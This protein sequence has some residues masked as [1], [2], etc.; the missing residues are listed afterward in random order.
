[1]TKTKKNSKHLYPQTNFYEYV[2]NDWIHSHQ[3]QTKKTPYITNFKIVSDKIDKELQHL[4]MNK[5]I[6]N[7]KNINNLFH[8]YIHN[9]EFIITNYIY[10]L[11]NEVRD[12]FKLDFH[13]G[14]YKLMAW[15]HEK[16]IH[17][18]L[19]ININNDEKDCSKYSLYIQESG[20]I[21]INEPN[22]FTENDKNSKEFM[23]KYKKLLNDLFSCI[24]GEN[25]EYNLQIIIDIQK[26]MCK[27]VYPP[28]MDRNTDKTYNVFNNH[29]DKNISLHLNELAP[30]LG[31]KRVPNMFIVENPEF[32][33]HAMNLMQK[34]W[35]DLLVYYIY[36]I[37]LLASNF[38]NKL[39]IIFQNYSRI[40]K[41][42]KVSTKEERAIS[43]VSNIMN[44]TVNKLYL[45]YY[46]NKKEIHLTKYIMKQ[47]LS[48]FVE[49]LKKNNWLS[50]STIKSALEK[51]RNLKVYIGT[52]PNWIEDPNI[53]FSDNIFENVEKY[54]SWKNKYF[55]EHFY[56]KTPNTSVWNRWNS[57]NTYTVNAFYNCNK[58]E[59]VI[60]N[61]ILQ[62]PFVNTHK[63][64]YYNLSSIGTII[65]HEISHGF[66]NHGSLFD[67]DGNYNK[68]WKSE[69]YVKY[70]TI[71]NNIKSYYLET[72]KH[73]KFKVRENLTLGENIA[74]ISGFQ[75][76]E[77]TLIQELVEN[78]IYGL[79]Q[80]KYLEEF[81]VNYAKLW[82]TVIHPNILKKL[83]V[84]D[85]H[86]YAKYRVNCTL[87]LSK[88]FRNIYN[89]NENNSTITI[90]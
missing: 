21:T 49:N 84:Y 38:H 69:D 61:G 23:K 89:L 18:L 60:P 20:I 77:Q 58:N 2:N 32:T 40:D 79:D 87:L 74:D 83:Y 30:Q 4:I 35:K 11:I 3:I 70:Q 64:I 57:F 19:S 15:G 86:S 29:T 82:K 50:S 9:D 59:I 24:F 8:S 14:I 90:F 6:K 27:Y 73:D 66:D 68:W 81:Y 36:N 72:A 65:A 51:C 45:K 1:M 56:Q 26:E 88:R 37:L 31:L 63:S 48:T 17:Q 44:T 55:I 33:K 25:H 53:I 16:N 52:K 39:F 10:L 47:L 42:V 41:N 75:L 43:L 54:F 12:I 76:A 71:Q 78:K 7:N 80:K 85:V 34:H 28:S 5:L 13:K 67:K 62:P 22:N 46:E